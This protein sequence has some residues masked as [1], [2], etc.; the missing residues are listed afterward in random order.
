MDDEN[1]EKEEVRYASLEH[2]D[3]RESMRQLWWTIGVTLAGILLMAYFY[4]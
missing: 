1:N 2:T 3:T 4:F